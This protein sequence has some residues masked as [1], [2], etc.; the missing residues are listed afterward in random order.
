MTMHNEEWTDRLS[1]YL[2]GELSDGEQREVA[3][4]LAGCAECA[5]ILEE[6][7]AV[8]GAAH[9]LTDAGPPRDLWSGIAE[10]IS[11]PTAGG[12]NLAPDAGVRQGAG[13]IGRGA[14]ERRHRRARRA[15]HHRPRRRAAAG[16]G[17]SRTRSRW[18]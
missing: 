6:L 11:V 7:Q 14:R 15:T 18:A 3:S 16:A 10:Q 4:H 1:D 2:D 5:L 13:G 9:Q 8:V 12:S 17:A